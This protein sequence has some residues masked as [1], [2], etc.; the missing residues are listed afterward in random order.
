MTLGVTRE[1]GFDPLI[2]RTNGEGRE[3]KRSESPRQLR[4]R[5][6]PNFGSEEFRAT[7]DID[8]EFTV[9]NTQTEVER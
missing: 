7:D 5:I 3:N 9:N 2:R 6:Y 4:K 8:N 1:N